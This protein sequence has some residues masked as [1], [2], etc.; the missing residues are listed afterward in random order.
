MPDKRFPNDNDSRKFSVD[1]DYIEIIEDSPEDI[2]SNSVPDVIELEPDDIFSS[3]SS[4]VYIGKR[5]KQE[6]DN[7][8]Y[9]TK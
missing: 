7:N 3:S 9:F 4:D 8:I 2:F 6:P 5:T 1:D